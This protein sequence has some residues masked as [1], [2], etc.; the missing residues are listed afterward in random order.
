MN[1]L[2][3]DMKAGTYE[4]CLSIPKH[5]DASTDSTVHHLLSMIQ[6]LLE[7]A[8]LHVWCL[9]PAKE[10]V[11]SYFESSLDCSKGISKIQLRPML[12]NNTVGSPESP[13]ASNEILKKAEMHTSYQH[14]CW[15]G[16]WIHSRVS[17]CCTSSHERYNID[18]YI[19]RT[20][21]LLTPIIKSFARPKVLIQNERTW[22]FMSWTLC[23]MFVQGIMRNRY[24]PSL[25]LLWTLDVIK[26]HDT[27][28]IHITQWKLHCVYY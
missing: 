9:S 2:T 24:S 5:I 16:H 15:T 6:A 22:W 14:D 7:S 23:S 26:Y 25:L 13:L 3:C 28:K 18:I 12:Q 4:L 11:N 27:C 21:K 1:A 8:L 17:C 19:Q 20:T 10:W